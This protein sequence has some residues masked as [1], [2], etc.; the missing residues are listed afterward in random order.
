MVLSMST[1]LRG[2]LMPCATN[3]AACFCTVS[4]VT[5]MFVVASLLQLLCRRGQTD[6][7]TNGQR[8]ANMLQGTEVAWPGMIYVAHN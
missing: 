7:S 2:A 6:P 5:G 4:S 1:A 3:W 8:A